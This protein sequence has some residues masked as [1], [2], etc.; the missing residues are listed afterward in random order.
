MDCR[1]L[2]IEFKFAVMRSEGRDSIALTYVLGSGGPCAARG[3]I[4]PDRAPA[5]LRRREGTCFSSPSDDEVGGFQGAIRAE[6]A[7]RAKQL[8]L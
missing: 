4:N 3:A 5:V 2:I 6:R 8:K 7:Q 1:P